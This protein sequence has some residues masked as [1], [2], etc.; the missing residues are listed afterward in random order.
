MKYF[1]LLRVSHWIKN[2]IILLPSLLDGT[3]FQKI[4][5]GIIGFFSFCL[6]ASAGYIFNDLMDL[7]NDRKH[8]IKKKRPIPSGS[9]KKSLAIIILSI[10]ILL[11]LLI[12][13]KIDLMLFWYL[14]GY[15]LIHI[16]YTKYLKRL[17][18]YD[19]L[20]LVSFYL[21]RLFFGA[22]LTDTHLTGWLVVFVFFSTLSLSVEKRYAE[23]EILDDNLEHRGYLKS[24]IFVLVAL[25]YSAVF[26]SLLVL[27]I[28]AYMILKVH[29]AEFYAAL[30]LLG[31]GVVFAFFKDKSNDDLIRKL[32]TNL[33]LFIMALVLILIYMWVI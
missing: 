21:L 32:T 3:F 33:P 14:I 26:V 29:Q 8:P 24:S 13:I 23:I 12:C 27:N 5:V 1:R 25:K 2:L 16:L 10:L 28:H 30:N 20:M 6:I 31:M 18:F 17:A 15:I 4:D 19:L 7:E 22:Q 9:V 11:G